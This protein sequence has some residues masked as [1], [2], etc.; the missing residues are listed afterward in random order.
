MVKVKKWYVERSRWKN[1]RIWSL[2]PITKHKNTS[3]PVTILREYLL[4]SGIRSHIIKITITMYIT[5]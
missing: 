2:L 3:K 4:S 1:R 5:K